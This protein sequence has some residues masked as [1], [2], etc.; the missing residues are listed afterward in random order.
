MIREEYK[1]LLAESY[2]KLFS[3]NNYEFGYS[4]GASVIMVED[5]ETNETLP[6]QIEDV[7]SFIKN[8]KKAQKM[9]K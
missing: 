8:L 2:K 6:I 3:D 4:S 1:T 5:K 7:D 9:A